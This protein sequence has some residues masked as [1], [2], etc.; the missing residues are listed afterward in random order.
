MY[1]DEDEYA[2]LDQVKHANWHKI[3]E[4]QSLPHHSY[5]TVQFISSKKLPISNYVI[6]KSLKVAGNQMHC[7]WWEIKVL[8]VSY[9]VYGQSNH[10][11]A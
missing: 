4:N 10:I 2:I 5:R 7:F 3:I 1:S 11:S 6:I 8:L 9:M